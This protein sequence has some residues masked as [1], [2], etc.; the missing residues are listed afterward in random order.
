[1]LHSLA[2]A[3]IAYFLARY[4]NTRFPGFFT[5][6]WSGGVSVLLGTTAGSVVVFGGMAAMGFALD[7]GAAVVRAITHGF[8]WAVVGAAAGIYHGR[9]KAATGEHGGVTS[10]PMKAWFGWGLMTIVTVIAA[11]AIIGKMIPEK[12]ST[13]P[14]IKP[15]VAIAKSDSFGEFDKPIF[16]SMNPYEARVNALRGAAASGV[17]KTLQTRAQTASDKNLGKWPAADVAALEASQTWWFF[18]NSVWLHISNQSAFKVDAITF[19]YA[20]RRCDVQPS[21]GEGTYNIYLQQSVYPGSEALIQFSASN[22]SQTNN[23]CLT[24]VGALG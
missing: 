1:M 4:L 8:I 2:C 9:Q 13:A 19:E 16:E 11:V 17:L 12:A 14:L 5:A 20:P 24:I 10:I 15:A 23:G 21:T 3:V 22:F 7:A 18:D 6:V